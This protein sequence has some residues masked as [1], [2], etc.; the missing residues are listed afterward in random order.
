MDIMELASR[1]HPYLLKNSDCSY[2]ES[3][4]QS[5]CYYFCKLGLCYFQPFRIWEG[6]QPYSMGAYNLRYQ[7]QLESLIS[8]DR[9]FLFEETYRQQSQN[10][11]YLLDMYKSVSVLEEQMGPFYSLDLLVDCL[12]SSSASL[13]VIQLFFGTQMI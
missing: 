3:S 13:I 10:G 5:Y 1:L 9:G 11:P 2:P 8:A 7:T 12:Y 4:F 6:T